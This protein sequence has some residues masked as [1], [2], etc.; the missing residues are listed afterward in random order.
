M[1]ISPF[2]N[3]PRR[4]VLKGAVAGSAMLAAPSLVKAQV[5]K[6]IFTRKNLMSPDAA[7]DVRSYRDGV[8]AMLA[9]PPDHPHNWYNNAM[10]HLLDCP[11]G[12]WWFCAWHRGY[13]G[14]FEEIIRLHSGDPEFA[15][16]YWDWTTEPRIPASF[17]SDATDLENNALDPTSGRFEADINSFAAKY[18]LS[19][20]ALWNNFDGMQLQQE[21]LRGNDSFQKFWD[22]WAGSV[23]VNFST[24]RSKARNKTRNNPDLTGSAAD[25]VRRDKVM[26]AL[27]P[28]LFAP[29]AEDK[30]AAFNSPESQT[31]H[32]GIGFSLLE[33]QPHNSVHNNIGGIM[34]TLLSSID[35]IFF[36]HHC[37]ID[38]LWDVWTRKQVKRGLSPL[39]TDEQAPRFNPEPFLFFVDVNGNPVKTNTK[40]ADYMDMERF[41][42]DYTPGTGE[43]EVQFPVAAMGVTSGNTSVVAN[44]RF[45]DTIGGSAALALSGDFTRSLD[46]PRSQTRHVAQIS[47]VPPAN[48]MGLRFD[49]FMSP[50]GVAPMISADSPELVGAFEFFGMVHEHTTPVTVTIDISDGL[51]R[52]E[53]M[54]ILTPGAE[55]DFTLVAANAEGSPGITRPVEGELKS[56]QIEAI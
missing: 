12:N 42:Y 52:L 25:N 55:L 13:L 26:S 18:K 48:V 33:G 7:K 6:K 9:L 20:Q 3:P 24:P 4:A 29:T 35:P 40:A 17:F 49:F 14:Y 39:P 10:V 2:S 36:M 34:P 31:H 11:H 28:K 56:V 51:D 54:G 47:F 23:L 22:G 21:S 41:G 50:K 30:R 15:L 8:A 46:A 19:T 53:A 27:R 5:P 38:R 44:G 45:S 37:N 16:P 43:D 32:E 1:P